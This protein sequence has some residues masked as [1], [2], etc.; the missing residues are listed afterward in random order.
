MAAELSAANK[1]AAAMRELGY[2]A[3][4]SEPAFAKLL[5][6]FPKPN[7]AAVAEVLATMLRTLSGLDDRLGVHHALA[8]VL[9][10]AGVKPEAHHGSWNFAVAVAGLKAAAPELNWAL[11]ASQLDSDAFAIP[12]QQAFVQLL[13][14]FRLATHEQFPLRAV[15]GRLWA[16]APAQLSFLRHAV[17]VPPEL[18]TFEGSDKRQPPLE[19]LAGGKSPLGTPNQA[20][21]SLDLLET[22][23]SLSTAGL[24][25]E[26]R[27]CSCTVLPRF[28]T[29]VFVGCIEEF[30]CVGD[31]PHARMLSIVLF[32]VPYTIIFSFNLVCP[33]YR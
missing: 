24:A 23:S 20:W 33:Y 13:S 10:G 31:G 25:A 3:T 26:V 12:D 1:L 18:F 6:Q 2:A 27:C 21:L 9:E 11:V 14:A 4:A 17:A 29:V 28:F 15:V 16:N 32:I 8:T 5:A 30:A 22:L 7:E 19:G